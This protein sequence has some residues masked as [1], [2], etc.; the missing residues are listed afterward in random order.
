[1]RLTIVTTYGGNMNKTPQL[2]TVADIR[3]ESNADN[4]VERCDC[5][6]QQLKY[7]WRKVQPSGSS[8][9]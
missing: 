2:T 8:S 1:M 6:A 9:V 3:V 7:S 4:N 5:S